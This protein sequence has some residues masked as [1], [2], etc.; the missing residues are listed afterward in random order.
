MSLPSVAIVLVQRERYSPTMACLSQLMA[1]TRY[2]FH[3]IYVDGN[4][5]D[6][7]NHYLQRMAK[8][9]LNLKLIRLGR[10]L[11]GNEARNY[12]LAMYPR[13]TTWFFW[14]MMCGLSR[15]GLNSSWPRRNRSRP[16]SWCRCS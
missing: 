13:W 11:R 5:P 16:M 4:S 15:A 12:G 9:H 7:I 2:P 1:A 8:R 6:S 14:T 10:H 3:L